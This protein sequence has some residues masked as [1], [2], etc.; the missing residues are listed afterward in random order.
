MQEA[1]GRPYQAVLSDFEEKAAGARDLEGETERL[2][3][4]RRA[5]QEALG[6]L[7]ALSSL[8]E[9]LDKNTLSGPRLQA[10]IDRN[11]KLDELGFSSHAAEVIASE[12]QKK[13]LDPSKAAVLLSSML[14]EHTTTDEAM[15]ALRKQKSSL[16]IQRQT[17]LEA[18]GYAKDEV[19]GIEEQVKV[20]KGQLEQWKLLEA[21]QE[22]LH[23]S[24]MDKQATEGAVQAEKLADEI[25]LLEG[26]KK[27][28]QDEIRRLES[29][30]TANRSALLGL[31]SDLEKIEGKVHDTK[32]LAVI[33]SVTKDPKSPLPTGEVAKTLLGLVAGFKTYSDANP[34][35]LPPEAKRLLSDLYTILGRQVRVAGGKTQ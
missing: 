17:A 34:K 20:K 27:V 14:E 3:R 29:E 24:A 7:H 8:K 23:R 2:R 12:L 13:G 5:L 25:A 33:A 19:R 30:V 18:Q 31:E 16:E 28:L 35:D 10:F 9:V 22:R 26:N 11:L 15:A 21:D 1:V 32:H 6:D 4:E